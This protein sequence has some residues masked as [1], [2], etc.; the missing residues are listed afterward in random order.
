MKALF[1]VFSAGEKVKVINNADEHWWE[2]RIA[3]FFFAINRFNK[4]VNVVVEF[5][6]T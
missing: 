5:S 2:V 3:F 1:F 4:F 6:G